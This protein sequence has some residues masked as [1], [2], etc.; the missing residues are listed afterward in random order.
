MTVLYHSL[1]SS[2]YLIVSLLPLLQRSR[3]FPYTTL[4]R[5]RQVLDVRAYDYVAG[6]AGGERPIKENGAAFDRWKIVPRMLRNIEDRDHSVELFGETYSFAILH[7]PIGVLSIIHDHGDSGSA[8]ACRE[9]GIPFIASSASTAPMEEIAREMGDAP[10]WFQLYW[11][12]DL[13]IVASF[14]RR[15]EKS[16]YTAIVVTLDTPMMAWRERDLK[17]VYLL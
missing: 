4:F 1:F 7:A 10:R 11:S 3:L 13:E 5:S 12:S 8:R 9:L 17:N 6:G 16:G 15:A 14:L 2:S